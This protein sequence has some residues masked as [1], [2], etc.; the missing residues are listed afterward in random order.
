MYDSIFFL[1]FLKYRANPF[2]L[3]W[4][5]KVQ[6]VLEVNDLWVDGHGGGETW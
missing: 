6:T 3:G 2:F 4:G 1:I 5:E